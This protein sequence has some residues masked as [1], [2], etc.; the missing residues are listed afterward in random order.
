MERATFESMK[1]KNKNLVLSY[2]R[3]NDGISRAAIAQQ[4]GLTPPT[5]SSLVKSLLDDNIIFESSIGESKGG[6]KPRLLKLNDDDNKVIG[7]YIGPKS[8]ETVVANIRGEIEST[9]IHDI[10]SSISMDDLESLVI[11]SI[12]AVMKPSNN[13][14][15]V[16]VAMHGFVDVDTNT[17]LYA[18]LLLQIKNFNFEFITEEFGLPIHVEND[19]RCKLWAEVSKVHSDHRN[20]LYVNLGHGVG[21]AIMIDNQL[22]NG[23]HNLAG[24]IGHSIIQVDGKQCE[25]GRRGCLQAYVSGLS[26]AN[27][28]QEKHTIN[29]GQ[30]AKDLL[31]LADQGNESAREEIANVGTY[32]G[33]AL[34]NHINVIDPDLIILGGGVS[35]LYPYFKDSL[36]QVLEN[37]NTSA[38]FGQAKIKIGEIKKS[39]SSQGAALLI[40]E[41]IF[42]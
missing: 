22:Y 14:L 39:A 36:N 9:K 35:N 1:N 26:I 24:E 25:C 20:I 2:I 37:G 33:T 17:S 32:L 19:V 13:Y 16:G 11:K 15:G 29:N 38:N 18:P 3:S 5:V 40:L 42:S 28:A 4:S 12:E 34:I 7:V 31:Q 23:S 27:K 6:R 8:V 41:K 21:G 10:D 30:T